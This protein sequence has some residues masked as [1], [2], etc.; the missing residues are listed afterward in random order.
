MTPLLARYLALRFLKPFFFGLGLFALLIFLGDF[1]DKMP[2]LARSPAPSWVVLEYLWLEVPYWAVRVVPMATLLAALFAVGGLVHSGEWLAVQASGFQPG[3]FFRPL[4]WLSLGIAGLSFAAQ[5]TVLPA[6]YARAQ[7]LWRE[8]VSPEWEWNKYQ[9]AVLLGGPG[10]FLT[11]GA[12]LVEEG[13]LERP[14]MD[15]YNPFGLELQLD[16]RAARWDAA[17][18]RWIFL[19]GIERRYQRGAPQETPFR[20][21]RSELRVPPRTLAPRSK[22]P[23]EMSLAET[24]RYLREGRN[25]GASPREA[26]AAL[27]AKIA[28]PFANVVLCA[29]GIPLALRFKAKR[30]LGFGAVLGLSFLYLAASEMGQ[31]VSLAGW[32]PAVL[33]AWGANLLFGAAAAW[34][35]GRVSA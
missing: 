1:F 2:R 19:D 32:V 18:S 7:R 4:L 31:A 9:D 20:E 30:A 21:L 22:A 16:A 14:V 3:R 29:L 12:L 24:L 34:S 33:G 8:R 28:Y 5:E 23:D 27:H 6:C 17:E 25:A 15:C 26:R 10:Q 35:W 11:A 13:R